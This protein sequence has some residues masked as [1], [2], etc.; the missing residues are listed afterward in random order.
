MT[1]IFSASDLPG[2][3]FLESDRASRA[4]DAIRREMLS[5]R[6]RVRA[7]AERRAGSAA[8]DFTAGLKLL[9]WDTARAMEAACEGSEVITRLQHQLSRQVNADL[10]RSREDDESAI[11]ARARALLLT[12]LDARIVD[13]P[14]PRK[15]RASRLARADL[16]PGAARAMRVLAEYR[17]TVSVRFRALKCRLQTELADL[18]LE[19]AGETAARLCLRHG[20]QGRDWLWWRLSII[21]DQFTAFSRPATLPASLELL[22]TRSVIS[23]LRSR[24]VTAN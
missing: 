8:D 13:R 19:M 15:P 12:S 6:T 2:G 22:A 24:W 7:L 1:D 11:D 5:L 17:E 21:V 3:A 20:R 9:T 4:T 16:T 18:S 10:L 14:S 23:E